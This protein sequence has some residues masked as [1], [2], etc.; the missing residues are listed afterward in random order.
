MAV[1]RI[2][3]RSSCVN[4]LYLVLYVS[5]QDFTKGLSL[6]ILNCVAEQLGQVVVMRKFPLTVSDISCEWRVDFYVSGNVDG[7]LN[8]AVV[9]LNASISFKYALA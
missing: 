5:E 6:D 9:I 8:V 3:P 7:A 4:E 1:E 2:V